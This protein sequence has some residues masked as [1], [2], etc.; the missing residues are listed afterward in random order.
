MIRTALISVRDGP[1][2]PFRDFTLFAERQQAGQLAAADDCLLLATSIAS[3][4]GCHRSQG[5]SSSSDRQDATLLRSF[6]LAPLSTEDSS[7]TVTGTVGLIMHGVAL[8]G[9]LG[10]A[11]PEPLPESRSTQLQHRRTLL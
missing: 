10:D 8:L 1:K 5:C 6:V 3:D 9:G 11:V 2:Y 4:T 7:A